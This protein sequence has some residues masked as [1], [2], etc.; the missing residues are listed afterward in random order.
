MDSTT[1]ETLSYDNDAREVTLRTIVSERLAAK[2]APAMDDYIV[3]TYFLA[4]RTKKLIDAVEEISYHATSGIKHPPPGSLLEECSAIPA[5]VD[6]F[7]A[8]GQLGLLHV[9]FP[10][11]MMLQPDGHLT[12][13]DIL[14][15]VAA[16]VIFDVYE[17]Q[18]A[19]LVSLQI[20]EQVLR[21]LP[22]PG[23]W[24]AGHPRRRPASPPPRP[25]SAPS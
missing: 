1:L 6:A 25:P 24:A 3:A 2:P 10:L 18:D 14:H 22:R 9:A 23:L 17:N 4:L 19:R 13:S 20:P 16:A 7:D 15:T 11:K 21:T 5:G 8:T 12:S